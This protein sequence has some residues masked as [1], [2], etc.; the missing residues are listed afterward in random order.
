MLSSPALP[1]IVAPCLGSDDVLLLPG[2]WPVRLSPEA[3]RDL[4]AQLLALDEEGAGHE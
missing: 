3:R 1:V 4:A 2:H